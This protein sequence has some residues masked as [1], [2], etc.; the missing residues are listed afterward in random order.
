MARERATAF[1]LPRSSEHAEAA[2]DSAAGG[3]VERPFAD[4]PL[5]IVGF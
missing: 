5:A 4:P 2:G 1:A 3:D